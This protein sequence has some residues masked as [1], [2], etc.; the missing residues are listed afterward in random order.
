MT[1]SHRVPPGWRPII[2]DLEEKVRVVDAYEDVDTGEL[3]VRALF[4]REEDR[5]LVDQAVERAR[6]TEKGSS[7]DCFN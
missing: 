5:R 1:V 3:V 2:L 4:S 6:V 7:D